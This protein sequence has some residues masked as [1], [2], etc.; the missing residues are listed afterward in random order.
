MQRWSPGTPRPPGLQEPAG[1]GGDETATPP[2]AS[3]DEGDR[4]AADAV[5]DEAHA[6]W[7]WLVATA[8]ALLSVVALLLSRHR[9][10][11]RRA[12]DARLDSVT[13]HIRWVEGSVVDQVLA[14]P[15]TV[16]AAATWQSARLHLHSIGHDLDSL[17]STDT[18]EARRHGAQRQ[19]GAFSDLALAVDRESSPT[20]D[21]SVE[22]LGARRADVVRAREVLRTVLEEVTPD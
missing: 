3:G 10:R 7:H 2:P 15:S 18:D 1:E 19:R 17:C 13:S 22:A 6:W 11:V 14:S 21:D 12:R 9:S 8:V 5:E 4:P 20:P 16:R